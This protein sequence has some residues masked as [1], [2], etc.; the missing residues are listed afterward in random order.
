MTVKTFEQEVK[1]ITKRNLSAYKRALKS[2][3]LVSIGREFLN[4]M[5]YPIIEKDKYV[6]IT[7]LMFV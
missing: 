5:F 2:K 3:S 4:L 7:A 1:E 6:K